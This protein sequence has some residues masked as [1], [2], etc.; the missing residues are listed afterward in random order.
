MVAVMNTPLI[1]FYTQPHVE[2]SAYR[3]TLADVSRESAKHVQG[4]NRA[5]FLKLRPSRLWE[6]GLY[7]D[8][9]F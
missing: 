1:V 6:Q 7:H 5:N 2:T 3:R 9:I 8:M 4:R